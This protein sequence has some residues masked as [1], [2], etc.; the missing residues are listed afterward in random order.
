MMTLTPLEKKSLE[1]IVKKG[2]IPG[3]QHFLFP[4]CVHTCKHLTSENVFNMDKVK[5]SLWY[6]LYMLAS[7]LQ[8][9][10]VRIRTSLFVHGIQNNL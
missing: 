8:S 7:V 1:H 10:F 5:I 4:H 3:N 2:K 6:T 9:R